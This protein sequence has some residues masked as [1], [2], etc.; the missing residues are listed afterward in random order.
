MNPSKGKTPTKRK[1]GMNNSTSKKSAFNRCLNIYYIACERQG[2]KSKDA[3][4]KQCR[5]AAALFDQMDQYETL[6]K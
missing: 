4:Q 6:T 2:R 1:A 5:L 3:Q